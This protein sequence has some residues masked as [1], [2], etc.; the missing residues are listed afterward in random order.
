MLRNIIRKLHATVDSPSLTDNTIT[1]ILHQ[2]DELSN[3]LE[4]AVKDAAERAGYHINVVDSKGSKSLQTAQVK[5]ALK[6]GEK[7]IIVNLVDPVDPSDVIKATGDMKVVLLNHVPADMSTLNKNVVFIGPD[8]MLAGKIQGEWLANYFIGKGKKEFKYIL[9]E[10]IPDWPPTIKRTSGAKQA[11]AGSG[12]TATEAVPPIIANYRR[13]E[14]E[15]MLIPL[16]RSGINY[17]AIIANNDEMALGAIGAMEHVGMDPSKKPIVGINATPEAVE[18]VREGKLAMTVFQNLR[19]QGIASFTAISNMLEGKPFDRGMRYDVAA[20][21]P[22]VIYVPLE[23]VTRNHIPSK[24]KY[25]PK[26][27]PAPKPLP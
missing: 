16:L 1:L 26:P 24:L 11:L 4:L 5:G 21:S 20:D 6:R 15:Q 3:A 2:R 10:G 18:A 14:S 8:D 12:I 22:Y 27:M 25:P 19:E 7:A 17:D 23:P 13:E 9:L